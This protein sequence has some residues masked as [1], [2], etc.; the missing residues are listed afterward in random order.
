MRSWYVAKTKP[1]Q[2]EQSSLVLAQRGLEVFLPKVAAWT[3]RRRSG[4]PSRLEPLFPGYLFA[5]LDLHAP[6]W[7]AAR[8]APGVAYF[9]GAEG[10]PSPLPDDLV[11]A[12]RLRADAQRRHGWRQP[13]QA[14]DRV[15]ITAGPL[16]GL[17]AVFDGTLSAS[18]RSRVF[19]A[20]LS[21]LVPV[22]IPVGFLRRAS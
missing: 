15:L 2:E 9:L 14:G 6:E 8:S 19:I 1:R 10:V 18:G 5:R 12:V 11:E 7:L 13:F 3:G 22:V 20:V 17:E 16:A 21:R 4:P